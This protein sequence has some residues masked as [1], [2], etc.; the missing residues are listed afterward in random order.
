[1]R[2]RT[3]LLLSVVLLAPLGAGACTA[4]RQQKASP[5]APDSSSSRNLRVLSPN[6]TRQ[7]LMEVM[8]GFTNALGVH[9]DHC[10]QPLDPQ[11]EDFD[12]A[13]DAKPAKEA[14]RQMIL[15]TRGLND[16]TILRV[17]PEAA[18]VQC[19]TCHRGHAVPPAFVPSNQRS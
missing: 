7:Q 17:N 14:A 10:H 18:P 5:A 12:F 15:M 2:A 11:M 9:C 19:G 16:A 1:M 6:L 4:Y 3:L 8:R 13:S